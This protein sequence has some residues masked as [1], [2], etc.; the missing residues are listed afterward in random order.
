MRVIARPTGYDRPAPRAPRAARGWACI[1][2][3]WS[4]SGWRPGQRKRVGSQICVASVGAGSR[5]RGGFGTVCGAARRRRRHAYIACPLASG[6]GSDGAA[7]QGAWGRASA[8]RKN[9]T[10]TTTS[11]PSLGASQPLL[12]RRPPRPLTAAPARP[13]APPPRPPAPRTRSPCWAPRACPASPPS[14]SPG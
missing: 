6:G 8:R 12:P 11:V 14:G 7:T 10:A 3:T 13:A 2:R 1:V 9:R 4:R 5:R